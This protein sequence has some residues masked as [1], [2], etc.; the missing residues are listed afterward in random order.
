MIA[1]GGEVSRK[2][3]SLL[4]STEKDE[5]DNAA[6]PQAL[7][8]PSELLYS[9]RFLGDRLYAVTFK[10]ID[11]LYVVDLSSSADPKI[12]GAV[13]LPGFS[14][15]L[16]P[17]PDG[18]LLGFGKDAVP[19]DNFADGQ[20]AWYQGLQLT[21]FDV[22]NASQPREL[23]R[24]AFGKRGSDSPLL[25]DHHALSILPQAD[26]SISIAFPARRV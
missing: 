23:Q 7:G 25:R 15:Y 22:S 18:L 13:E 11:P 9:T 26:G 21:L 5:N 10:K 2:R 24:V 17:L 20:F 16:H 4:G 12:A 19:A 1:T 6:R 14:D 8:K 3:R